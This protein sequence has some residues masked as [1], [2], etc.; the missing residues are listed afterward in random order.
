MARKA[1]ISR[2]EIIQACWSLLEQNYF[3]NIPRLTEHF[4]RQDGRKCSNTTFLKAITEWE[5]LYKERQEASFKDLSDLLMP[6]FKK[7]E[8]DVS[9]EIQAI[10][11][12]KIYQED[13]AQAL[14]RDAILGQYL[15]LSE[16]VSGQAEEIEEKTVRV[17]ELIE[18]VKND[19]ET[20]KYLELRYQETLTTLKVL[21]SR[22]NQQESQVKELRLNLAQKELDNH[23]LEN[24]LILVEEDRNRLL[25]SLNEQHSR[26]ES[27]HKQ[28][29]KRD[30][31][32]LTAQIEALINL[33][34]HESKT[35]SE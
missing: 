20:I 12:E 26:N 27:L 22:F 29:D 31:Q 33:Q 11:E 15:S 25:Q 5:E 4:V 1:N 8:R 6:S 34:K 28:L 30:F 16:L 23:K 9:R 19:E 18:K 17:K 3:P 24:K 13:S 21:Q 35:K 32:T 2:E 7:F 10:F 14:K